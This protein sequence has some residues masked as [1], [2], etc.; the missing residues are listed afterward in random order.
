MTKCSVDT[1]RKMT[2][3]KNIKP[4]KFHA[5]GIDTPVED[6][7]QLCLVFVKWLIQKGYISVEKLPVHNHAK[8]GKYFINSKPQH[9]L[10]EKDA[11]WQTIGPYC[12]DT[13]YNAESHVKNILFAL[14]HLGVVNPQ[15]QISFRAD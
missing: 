12:I 7:T 1:L 5:D 8:R 11:C 6:W 3:N 13:K 15:F 2:F 4:Y 10:Q 14:K 9:Q